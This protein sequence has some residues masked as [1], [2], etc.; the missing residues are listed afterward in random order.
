MFTI[1]DLRWRG[2]I[3]LLPHTHNLLLLEQRNYPYKTDGII[4]RGITDID[5][6]PVHYEIIIKGDP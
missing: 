3:V 1:L 5:R 4:R 2:K 6:D